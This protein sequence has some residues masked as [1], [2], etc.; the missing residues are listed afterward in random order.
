MKHTAPIVFLLDVDNTLLDNDGIIEDLQHHLMQAFSRECQD[1]YWN[2][3]EE[4][5]TQ[6]GYA[7]YLGALQRYR[8]ENPCDQHVLE[9]GAYL[10]DYPFANRLYPGSINVIEHLSTWGPTVILSDGD[11][12]FQ[13]RKVKASGLAKAVQ[14]R[15]LIYIHK[16]Q[17][18]DDVEKHFPARHYVLVDDKICILTEAKKAWKS[19]LTTIFP[20]QGHYARDPELVKAYPSADI[21]I[22]NV[23]E[24]LNYNLAVLLSAGRPNNPG[25]APFTERA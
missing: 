21:T 9:I 13:P 23:G 11:I 14:D 16:E 8:D 19:R 25:A 3:F 15:V 2:I 5:R 18:L 12:I 4:R 7:D 10:L 17:V 24:L 1:R 22:E 20:H 6:L